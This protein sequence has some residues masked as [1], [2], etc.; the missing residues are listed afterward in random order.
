MTRVRLDHAALT[1]AAAA[2]LIPVVDEA[3]DAGVEM[4]QRLVPIDSGDLHDDIGV[5]E[6]AHVEDGSVVGRY[7]VKGEGTDYGPHVEFGTEKMGA[8]PF[9]RPSADA[10]RRA[11]Q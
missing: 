6:A 2:A 4:A 1:A 3:M 9:I 7:G 8:Q 10:A 11:V 5:V